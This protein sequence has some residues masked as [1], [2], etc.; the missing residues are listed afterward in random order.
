MSNTKENI[1]EAAAPYIKNAA[2]VSYKISPTP[3]NLTLNRKKLKSCFQNLARQ[4]E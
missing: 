4:T 3:S 2:D 1:K